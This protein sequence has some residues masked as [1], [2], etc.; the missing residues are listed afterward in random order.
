MRSGGDLHVPHPQLAFP[1]EAQQGSVG[2]RVPALPTGAPL[3]GGGCDLSN[4]V[5]GMISCVT[6][7][8]ME[9]QVGLRPG[10][11]VDNGPQEGVLL[12]LGSLEERESRAPMLVFLI[13]TFPFSQATQTDKSPFCG[14]L[15]TG[16]P[17][18]RPN[19][20]TF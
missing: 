7:L 15:S 17:G 16:R 5:L 18:M 12:C 20:Q 2:R 6:S 8:P 1:R 9:D 3:P 19:S 13:S 4:S 10:H 14:P 11:P